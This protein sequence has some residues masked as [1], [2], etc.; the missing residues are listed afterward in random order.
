MS[1][2]GYT[3]GGKKC[4]LC[5]GTGKYKKPNDEEKYNWRFDVYAE[6]LSNGEARERALQEAGYTVIECPNCGGSGVEPE[7]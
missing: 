2:G 6:F 5:D 7:G 3:G 4:F 1:K